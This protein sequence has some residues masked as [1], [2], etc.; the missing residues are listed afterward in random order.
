MYLC[1]LSCV[2]LL[3]SYVFSDVFS[4]LFSYVFFYVFSHVFSYY[5]RTCSLTPHYTKTR[6][7]DVEVEEELRN[8]FDDVRI[9]DAVLPIDRHKF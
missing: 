1:V 9:V 3:L 4:Y 2:F 5:S 8:P 6:Q 7:D